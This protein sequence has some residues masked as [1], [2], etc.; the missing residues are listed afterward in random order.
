[1][2]VIVRFPFGLW[3]QK[4]KVFRIAQPHFNEEPVI[5]FDNKMRINPPSDFAQDSPSRVWRSC[6]DVSG[7]ES[8][9]K[10]SHRHPTS[11]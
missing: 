1:M 5:I 8:G 11:F 9:K 6:F 7:S 2:A 3:A 10:F 4:E